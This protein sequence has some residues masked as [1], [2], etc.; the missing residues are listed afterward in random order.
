MGSCS[1][2]ITDS[3]PSNQV[4]ARSRSRCTERAESAHAS[5]CVRRAHR[6]RTNRGVRRGGEPR[7]EQGV[8]ARGARPTDHDPVPP[9]NGILLL[10]P[11]SSSSSSVE[12]NAP[13][14]EQQKIGPPFWPDPRAHATFIK[15]EPRH[16]DAPLRIRT[17][18]PIGS[19]PVA[20]TAPASLPWQSLQA[21]RC[22]SQ[23]AAGTRHSTH[24][25]THTP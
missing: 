20:R 23:R 13:A 21:P 1:F 8:N 22:S 3:V 6:A 5:R 24:T 10:F 19:R 7:G 9:H 17:A 15:R 16:G 25:H 4:A 11:S 14:G 12:W 18:R 2:S